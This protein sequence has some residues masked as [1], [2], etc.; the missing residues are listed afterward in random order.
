MNTVDR[1]LAYLFPV[2][3]VRREAARSLI[4]AV[5]GQSH[6]NGAKPG[7]RTGG[8]KPGTGANA[9]RAGAAILRNEARDLCRNNPHASKAVLVM[10]NHVVGKGLIPE[11][12]SARSKTAPRIAQ[13]LYQRWADDPTPDGQMTH[14]AVQRQ[15]I[16]AVF[17]D[18]EVLRRWS[19]DE[20][21]GPVC[22]VL[23][24]DHLDTSKDE[25]ARDGSGRVIIQGIEFDAA[26]RRVAYWI[27]P[28]HPGEVGRYGL[29]LGSE[30]VDARW[31][32]H[33]FRADRP[34]AVRG[35]TAFA[36]VM[37]A[38]RDLG[39]LIES[40]LIRK[41]VEG[42]LAAIIETPEAGA[43][44]PRLG[45]KTA[46]DFEEPEA[47]TETLR[48]GMIKALR[49]GEKL[50]SFSPQSSGDAHEFSKLILHSISAGL[51]IP[52]HLL[53][54]DVREAN[55]S[56]IRAGMLDFWTLL[57]SWQADTLIPQEACP[58]W[59]RLVAF[60]KVKNPSARAGLDSVACEW[61]AP[62]RQFI[63]PLKDISATEKEVEAGFSSMPRA[64]KARGRNWKD[65]L[66]AQAE[67]EAERAR[68]LGQSTKESELN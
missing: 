54:N 25:V 44:G 17:R 42:M 14:V 5:S 2:L 46:I 40:T 28:A 21:R 11:F 23:E 45:Q 31:V 67:Y 58:V 12:T 47:R 43:L 39:E 27:F 64:L 34:G 6:Y 56:S 1:A 60:E 4:A 35:V 18:G 24:I 38:L 30:R 66:S 16:G 55:Y 61:I 22:Q 59:R 13:E 50:S 19:I 32:D 37:L 51:T 20:A 7:R 57:D 68:L 62:A 3:A 48:P 29:S 36:P 15:I 41:K 33:I 8:R 10:E 53:T 63:D 52:Y 9:A 49:P 26:G 65:E